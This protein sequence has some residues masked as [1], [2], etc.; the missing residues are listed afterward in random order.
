MECITGPISKMISTQGMQAV[1]KSLDAEGQATFKQ[2]C[3]LL[4]RNPDFPRLRQ[5]IKSTVPVT[6]A[7]VICNSEC[8]QH[9]ALECSS[10]VCLV[11][12]GVGYTHPTPI[13]Q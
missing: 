9:V 8:A 1:Y 3:A 11:K 6:G 2:V 5:E 13:P 4:I 7:H 12:Q 10:A